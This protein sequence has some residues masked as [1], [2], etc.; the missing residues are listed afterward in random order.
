MAEP[1]PSVE[2]VETLVPL[3]DTTLPVADRRQVR[4]YLRDVFGR[5]R[6]TRPRQASGRSSC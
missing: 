1:T 4:A 5:H 3:E 2:L 6:S